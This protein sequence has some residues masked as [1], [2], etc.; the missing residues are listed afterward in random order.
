VIR[1]ASRRIDRASIC[2]SSSWIFSVVRGTWISPRTRSIES[3]LP[4]SRASPD[5]DACSVAGLSGR[6]ASCRVAACTPLQTSR[7]CV[8]P[9]ARCSRAVA[10]SPTRVASGT[11]PVSVIV[12]PATEAV[13]PDVEATSPS[14]STRPSAADTSGAPGAVRLAPRRTTNPKPWGWVRLPVRVSSPSALPPSVQPGRAGTPARSTSSFAW[15]FRGALVPMP[16]RARS[17]GSVTTA[18]SG[19]CPDRSIVPPAR[20]IFT[21]DVVATSPASSTCPSVIVTG[22]R[23]GR[24][25]VTPRSVNT[26]PVRGW[27]SVP[28]T[29]TSPLSRPVSCRSGRRGRLAR[30]TSTVAFTSIGA[31]GSIPSR[32]RAGGLRRTASGRRPERS[33]VPPASSSRRPRAIA[34]SPA[35]STWPS[36]TARTAASFGRCSEASVRVRRPAARGRDTVP[37]RST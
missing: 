9:G 17:P 29:V 2:S 19:T 18:A 35:S 8:S 30:S 26:P 34:E 4:S 15:M 20:L 16:S 22:G 14:R 21:P 24:V 31:A 28:V 11:L 6:K 23:P 25:T 12:P 37:V 33:T 13:M 10:V 36:F 3:K 32:S 7:S 5:R 27:S 1:P